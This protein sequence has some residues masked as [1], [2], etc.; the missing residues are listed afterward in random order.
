MAGARKGGAAHLSG[1]NCSK[2]LRFVWSRMTRVLMKQ[3]RSSFFAL[4]MDI[5][6]VGFSVGAAAGA[7]FGGPFA[8]IATE[9]FQSGRL[10]SLFRG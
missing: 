5:L 7:W 2:T 4:N 10:T 3:P 8:C 9:R 6:A 1:S